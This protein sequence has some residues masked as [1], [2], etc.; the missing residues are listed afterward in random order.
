MVPL[1]Y[2]QMLFTQLQTLDTRGVRLIHLRLQVSETLCTQCGVNCLPSPCLVTTPCIDVACAWSCD[3]CRSVSMCWALSMCTYMPVSLRT[4]ILHVVW[5][6]PVICERESIGQAYCLCMRGDIIAHN[7]H[8]SGI[9][10]G[11]ITPMATMEMCAFPS[12]VHCG[13]TNR[14]QT[15]SSSSGSQAWYLRV[16]AL[17]L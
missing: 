10:W 17:V 11:H 7:F 13:N 15:S 3:W 14:C 16:W 4:H 6:I 8:W 2:M 12:K 1:L 9:G 5:E